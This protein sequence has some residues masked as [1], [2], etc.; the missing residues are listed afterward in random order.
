MPSSDHVPELIY[1]QPLPLAGTAATAA[2]VSC[3]QLATTCEPNSPT[4]SEMV[5]N[6]GPSTV[7]EA[8][9]SA[10]KCGKLNLR[11]RVSDQ[12]RYLGS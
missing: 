4:S 11:K 8:T 9:I 3:E 10:V 1:A 12:R 2:A 7:P 6:I 5:G